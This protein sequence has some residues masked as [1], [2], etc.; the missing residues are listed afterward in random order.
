MK[1][2][3]V[4]SNDLVQLDQDHPGFRDPNYRARR[5]HIAALALAHV[6]GAPP[7]Q[8]EYLPAEH[9]VWRT[10]WQ[11]LEPLLQERAHRRVLTAMRLLD[12][13]RDEIPQFTELAPTLR[14]TTGFRLDPVAGLVSPAKFMRTLRDGAFLATQYIRHTSRPLYTPEPDVVHELVGHATTLTDPRIARLNQRFGHAAH[15]ATDA[16]MD[17]LIRAY[18]YTLE[19]GLVIDGGKPR[20]FG[21]GL[22]SSFGELGEFE[23]RAQLL[24]LDLARVAQTPFDPTDYQRTLFVADSLEDLEN[25]LEAFFSGQGL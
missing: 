13:H 10:I 5:N 3:E 24:P 8:I 22:L 2:F 17:G 7:P 12:A 15:A 18:W 23:T 20:A 16:Q 14:S 6:P 21:A 1:G 19:F 25:R 9:A 11:N 4:D